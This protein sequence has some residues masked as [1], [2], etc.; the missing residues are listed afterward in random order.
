SIGTA[1]FMKTLRGRHKDG[2]VVIK[3]FIKPESGMSLLKQVKKFN[4]ERE[5]LINVPNAFYFQRILNTDR[6]ALL[7]RQYLYS[8]LY[9]RISTRPF[10]TVIE[11]KWIAYQLLK[12]VADSHARNVYHGDI[13]TEN[14]LVTSWNWVFLVDYAFYKPTYLPEDNPADF[15]FF[16]DTSY[17]RT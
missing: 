5:A 1:R 13:K 15:S 17:R 10:L 9:D 7:V 14:V 3:L 8:S 16:F 12:G 4:E 11:K 2:Y 6:A